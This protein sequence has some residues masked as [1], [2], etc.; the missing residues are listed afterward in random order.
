M[1]EKWAEELNKKMLEAAERHK[2]TEGMVVAFIAAFDR[3]LREI[4]DSLAG[5]PASIQLGQTSAS[6]H[7]AD[8]QVK[9]YQL[10]YLGINFMHRS[11]SIVPNVFEVEGA[12][13]CFVSFSSNRPLKSLP[14]N[15]LFF[16]ANG[17]QYEWAISL[18]PVVHGQLPKKTRKLEKA[19]LGGILEQ[20]L[21]P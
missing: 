20:S 17:D 4:Q 10:G 12:T 2:K 1:A 13:L 14:S 8:G 19:D 18:E 3:L 15:L 6:F 21:L 11:L 9:Q 16:I 7:G 5:G